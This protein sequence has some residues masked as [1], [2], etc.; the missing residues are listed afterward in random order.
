MGVLKA[1]KG[2]KNYNDL[3]NLTFSLGIVFPQ[4]V[5]HHDFLAKAPTAYFWFSDIPVLGLNTHSNQ[6]VQQIKPE[7]SRQNVRALLYAL[8]AVLP[9]TR[10]DVISTYPELADLFN[11]T[12]P[13]PESGT[14]SLFTSA[15]QEVAEE[16][17]QS[18]PAAWVIALAAKALLLVSGTSGTGKSRTARDIARSFDYPLEHKYAATTTAAKPSNSLA[19]IPVGA[20]WTDGSPLLGFRNMFGSLRNKEKNGDAS[21]SSNERWDPPSALRLILR[22]HERPD[23]PHFLVLDEMNLSH[24]ERYFNDV[25]SVLEINR[26]LSSKGKA[27]LLDAEAVRLIANTLTCGS[28][29][30]LERDVAVRLANENAGVVL[31]D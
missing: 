23:Q 19:F 18:L 25:L 9:G 13:S 8:E 28:E 6:T 1:R 15:P 7:D 2:G 12:P 22:A 3:Q 30:P 16:L 10:A 27:R 26:G 4:S 21:T 11:Y 24:V 5:A 14:A 17:P 29:F 20:D 31:P